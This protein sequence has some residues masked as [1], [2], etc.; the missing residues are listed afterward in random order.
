MCVCIHLYTYEFAYIHNIYL[1]LGNIFQLKDDELF[2]TYFYHKE[3]NR[4]EKHTN[5]FMATHL[6]KLREGLIV[7]AVH[8]LHE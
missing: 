6:T 3:A 5:R 8:M 2:D 1:L 7:R 4:C